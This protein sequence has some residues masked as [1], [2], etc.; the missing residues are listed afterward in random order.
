MVHK[1]FMAVTAILLA[2]TAFSTVIAQEVAYTGSVQFSTGNYIF[3][4]RT[5]SY[6]LFNG[7]SISGNRFQITANF[8]LI[9]QNTPLIS[10]TGG[11]M[12][13][14]GGNQGG[15]IIQR[16]RGKN[17]VTIPY[18]SSQTD[19]I[20]VG[21][22]IARISY[23][24]VEGKA[25]LPAIHIAAS[26]KPPFASYAKGYGTG[27]WDYAAGI[28][29]SKRFSNS[30]IFTNIDYWVFGDPPD[31]KLK[32]AVAYS[33]ALG[34]SLGTGK[35]GLLASVSGYSQIISGVDPPLYLGTGLNYY[36]N[37]TSSI[38]ISLSFGLTESTPEFSLALGWRLKL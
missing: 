25:A 12:M 15:D 16:R 11:V 9:Y 37:T 1:L 33:I 34:Q 19:E 35:V 38:N 23:A 36:I 31:L 4:D 17:R 28:S 13:P 6:Y 32:D 8:P 30:F 29:I 3:T 20:G 7:L 26:F 5:N 22:P 14:S 18:T 10:Y 2:I 24:I 27:E 21:D